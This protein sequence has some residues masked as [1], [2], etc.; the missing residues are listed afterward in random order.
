MVA[1]KAEVTD[2]VSDISKKCSVA[3]VF[4]YKMKRFLSFR[5][6]FQNHFSWIFPGNVWNKE[7]PIPTNMHQC[8]DS[9]VLC[10]DQTRQQT[11]QPGHKNNSVPFPCLLECRFKSQLRSE[12]EGLR[13]N[14]TGQTDFFSFNFSYFFHTDILLLLHYKKRSDTTLSQMSA[15]NKTKWPPNM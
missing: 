11:G 5:L 12:F 8:I 4:K 10:M 1:A 13:S 2:F 9:H 15:G 6:V 7:P 3:T 14:T